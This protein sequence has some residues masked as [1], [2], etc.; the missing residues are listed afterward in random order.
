LPTTKEGKE[1]KIETGVS[2]AHA[3]GEPLGDGV[4]KDGRGGYPRG[5]CY[6]E[7]RYEDGTVWIDNGTRSELKPR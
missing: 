1:K 7:T 5:I 2:T 3:A 6:S 4:R